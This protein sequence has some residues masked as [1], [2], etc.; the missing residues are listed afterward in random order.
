MLL[1]N[2]IEYTIGNLEWVFFLPLSFS[3]SGYWKSKK[4]AM[5]YQKHM[6][7]ANLIDWVEIKIMP[8][9]ISP[10]LQNVWNN[11]IMSSQN[12]WL[13]GNIVLVEIS[14]TYLVPFH[15]MYCMPF[16][17]KKGLKL[18]QSNNF[19]SLFV[20]HLLLRLQL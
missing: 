9:V 16:S 12:L 5:T 6:P 20:S 14:Y 2:M 4:R 8:F 7:I 11:I 10:G 19:L 17:F 18:S 13:I 3:T 15:C 1:L